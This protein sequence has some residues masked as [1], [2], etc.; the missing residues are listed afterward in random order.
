M[1]PPNSPNGRKKR[2]AMRASLP[3]TSP[4]GEAIFKLFLKRYI[5][6]NPGRIAKAELLKVQP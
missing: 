3:T 2:V 6:N 1:P 5:Y 4:Q